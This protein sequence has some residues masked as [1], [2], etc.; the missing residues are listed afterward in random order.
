MISEPETRTRLRPFGSKLLVHFTET[1]EQTTGGVWLPQRM[2]ANTSEAEVVARGFGR[3]VA[4]GGI[5]ERFA[6]WPCVGDIV[7][8]EPHRA[9]RL[10]EDTAVIDAE[11]C[12]AIVCGD[13]VFPLSDWVA[14]KPESRP[15]VSEGGVRLSDRVQHF[16]CRGTILEYGCGVLEIEGTCARR[17]KTVHEILNLPSDFAL[18]GV[19]VFWKRDATIIQLG[20]EKVELWLV[21]AQDLLSIVEESDDAEDSYRDGEESD[22]SLFA[23]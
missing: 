16:R 19:D 17:R 23:R 9:H 20:R 2:R 4:G 5:E 21:K 15:Q 1:A 8:F 18:A 14:V 13:Q 22:D 11:D 10:D 12:L 6:P 7:T 3:R